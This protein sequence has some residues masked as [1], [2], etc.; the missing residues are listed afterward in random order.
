MFAIPRTCLRVAAIQFT[1]TR[2]RRLTFL[3]LDFRL[4]RLPVY[5]VMSCTTQLYSARVNITA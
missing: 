2:R 5:R 4:C 3:R 1:S